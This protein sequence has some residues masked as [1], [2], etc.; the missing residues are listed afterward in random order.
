MWTVEFIKFLYFVVSSGN[1][2]K[3]DGQDYG[4]PYDAGDLIT[5]LFDI[6]ALELRFSL[7]GV[8]Q[9]VAFSSSVLPP[10]KSWRLA[11]STHTATVTL[12]GCLNGGEFSKLTCMF[13]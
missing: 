8:S 1:R 5:V 9:G 2:V 6:D 3:T 4:T 13:N 12:L 7:N 11:V 10:G